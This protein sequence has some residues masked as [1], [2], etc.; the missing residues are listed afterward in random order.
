MNR[1]LRKFAKYYLLLSLWT[2]PLLAPLQACKQQKPKGQTWL[3]KHEKA[4]KNMQKF[5]SKSKVN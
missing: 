5:N 1:S 3:P 4:K 2:L